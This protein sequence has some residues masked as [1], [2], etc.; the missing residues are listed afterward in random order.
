LAQGLVLD[1]QYA[2]PRG[3]LLTEL[4]KLL[5]QSRKTRRPRGAAKTGAGSCKTSRRSPA[6][7]HRTTKLCTAPRALNAADI[8]FGSDFDPIFSLN[9]VG[10]RYGCGCAIIV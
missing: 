5:R 9:I 3:G 10:R 6:P 1:A 4:I 8:C 7:S 2:Y